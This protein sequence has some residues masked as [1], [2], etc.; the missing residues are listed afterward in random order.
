MNEISSI[1]RDRPGR[2]DHAPMLAHAGG[3]GDAPLLTQY[4]RILMRS[5]WWIAG[6]IL[7]CFL[8]GVL[9]TLL[10]TPQYTAA[11]RIEISR[12]GNRIV[13]VA[14]VQPETSEIDQEF[15]QTQYGVLNSRSLAELVARELRLADDR[16]FFEA[17]REEDGLESL[18]QS[19]AVARS[20]AERT[21]RSKI[22]VGLLLK[23]LK[24]EPIR[25]SRL[26]DIEWTSPS[27]QLSARVANAWATGYVEQN[28]NRRFDQTSYARQFLERRLEQL[29]QRLAESERA[30]V[31]YA[32]SQAIINI[33]VGTGADKSTVERSLTAD[34]L[35]ALNEELGRA[36]ADRIRAQSRLREAGGASVEQIANPA[37]ASLRQRRAE[38]AAELAR[39]LSQFEVG[40]PL[41]QAQ[42]AQVRTL[43]QAIVRE[44]NRVSG[45]IR[46]A[47]DDAV[48]R[49][50]ELKQQ[51]DTLKSA[52]LDLRRRSIQYNIYQ[53][54]VDT[55][56]ELYNGLL[57]RYKEIGVAGGVGNNNIS[58]IDPAKQPDR[59]SRPRPFLNL[60]IALVAGSILGV[61]LALIREQIDES[62]QD[63]GDMERRVGLPMLGAI[64]LS[65]NVDPRLD[66]RDT[67]SSVLE[68]Y[69][70][71]QTSLAF[72]S[73]HGIP[74]TLAI[75]S[76]RAAEGKS[77]TSFALAYTI[78]RSGARTILI[79]GDLR[80][81][82]IDDY[83]GLPNTRGVSN[84]LSGENDLSSLIQ[85][86]DDMPFAVLT[87][88]PQP[89][90]AAELLRG[91]RLAMLLEE[92]QAQYDH[93][94]VDA[95]PVLGLADAPIIAS[96]VE[97]TIFVIQARGVRARI[98]RV[99]IARLKQ[100][101]AQIVGTLLT[102]F[103]TKKTGYG[104]GYD[105]GY[106][107]GNG[108]EK[109]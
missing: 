92:L 10:T 65:K 83:L 50:T 51:V 39:T 9:V 1:E 8:I 72:S 21:K 60:L 5:R 86:P 53:R 76:T 66:M 85:T 29:R 106:G 25:A 41:A 28:L 100:A 88:G 69:L 35:A 22:V 31:N 37:L 18:A 3:T 27:A 11:T 45:S 15:Y 64:P 98:A 46:G 77:T 107:Y 43:E 14:G 59:P 104:Y 23:N 58:V 54:D 67:K 34:T 79:D 93:I 73:N 101:N 82:S 44:E 2:D 84:Y 94:V 40:Y 95:P 49:E 17:F 48:S 4:A 42:T 102:K 30:L 96:Q 47:Y 13:N 70:S 33:P 19:P 87:A 57:Q 97:A 78:A 20:A 26:V 74:R 52:F 90:N 89:P 55:N 108:N 63:P 103:D 16:S 12:D 61:A 109:S 80:S 99:A 81:P 91:K 56:R 38:A 68:A 32:S 6:A 36:T 105:Y 24:I 7:T 75:T 71:V 62:I